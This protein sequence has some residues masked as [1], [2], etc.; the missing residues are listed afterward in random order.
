MTLI[1]HCN[2]VP[3]RNES[4][5]RITFHDYAKISNGAAMNK[6]IK[7][8]CMIFVCVYIIGCTLKSLSGISP[9]AVFR[10]YNFPVYESASH[11]CQQHVYGSSGEITWDALV[12]SAQP[13]QVASFYVERLGTKT[14]TKDAGG[15]TW[16]FPAASP[17]PD[18]VL[19]IHPLTANGPWK[20]CKKSVPLDAK[21]VIM[22]S[23]MTRFRK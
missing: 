2:T 13:D 7:C 16:R 14:M 10:N 5:E 15:R 19:S 21:T 8:L 22:L 23:T 4:A 11:L 9:D 3:N 1:P 6:I 12:T 20:Q 18:R 17:E